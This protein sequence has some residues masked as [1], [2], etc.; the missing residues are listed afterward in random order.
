MKGPSDSTKDNKVQWPTE[1]IWNKEQSVERQNNRN[2]NA[3][4]IMYFLR[5]I[6]LQ[7]VAEITEPKYCNGNYL[8]YLCYM[9][10]DCMKFSCKASDAE[11]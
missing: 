10:T 8:N 6:K 3:I 11:K 5:C 7:S 1:L 2:H 9:F 4:T